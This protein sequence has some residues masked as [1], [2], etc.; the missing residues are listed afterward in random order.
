MVL[1]AV[2]VGLAGL[3]V[4]LALHTM[5]LEMAA[6]LTFKVRLRVTALEVV[7]EVVEQIPPQTKRMLSMAVEAELRWKV[8]ATQRRGKAAPLYSVQAG[9]VV[10]VLVITTK[11]PVPKEERGVHTSRVEAEL[12]VLAMLLVM[13]PLVL[14]ATIIPLDAVM[15]AV[16][17]E[18]AVLPLIMAEQVEQVGHREAV[19][20][21][22]AEVARV[23]M[24]GLAGLARLEKSGCGFTDEW[25]NTTKPSRRQWTGRPKS[26]FSA[27]HVYRN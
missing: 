11:M 23:A 17:V 27:H 21:Q 7:V 2:V 22:G 16:L 1:A 3:A 12:A 8:V 6:T 18:V 10:V 20:E 14:M 19:V 13:P 26:T 9:A 4:L 5:P 24:V 25:T 15:A